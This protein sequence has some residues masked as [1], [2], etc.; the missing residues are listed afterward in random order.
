MTRANDEVQRLTRELQRDAANHAT[1]R[2]DYELDLCANAARLERLEAE[3]RDSLV[4]I[5]VLNAKGALFDEVQ[6]KLENLERSNLGEENQREVMTAALQVA[7]QEKERILDSMKE[8]EHTLD[9]LSMDKIYL[10]KEIQRQAEQIKKSETELERQQEKLREVKRSR[11]ELYNKFLVE[12]DSQ[13]AIKQRLQAEIARI[14]EGKNQE[15]EQIRK[16]AKATADEKVR[17]FREMRDEAMTATEMCR[18]ELRDSKAAYDELL[19]KFRELHR[20]SELKETESRGNLKVANFELDRLKVLL[21]ETK[22]ALVQI[23]LENETWAA[24]IQILKEKVK[25]EKNGPLEELKYELEKQVS[26]LKEE[27]RC[28]RAQLVVYQEEKND[29]VEAYKK[30]KDAK[31]EACQS[32]K[33]AQLDINQIGRISQPHV[34]DKEEEAMSSSPRYQCLEG[35]SSMK[36][37]SVSRKQINEEDLP[38]SLWIPIQEEKKAKH[39]SASR[40][41]DCKES[42]K[43]MSVSISLLKSCEAAKEKLFSASKIKATESHEAKSRGLFQQNQQLEEQL[44][45]VTEEKNRVTNR[46]QSVQDDIRKLLRARGSV[47]QLQSMLKEKGVFTG[48]GYQWKTITSSESSLKAVKKASPKISP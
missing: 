28:T 46:L 43:P 5:E 18:S 6:A 14:E 26:E 31:C 40:Y 15:V 24:K 13:L 44:R 25:E 8:K 32:R 12:K 33:D 23:K 20:V 34:P 47:E 41:E 22:D 10:S 3:H 4:Q 35:K 38:E 17:T 36:C 11:S 16:E 19:L 27:L 42:E 30:E 2:R 21:E 7:I 48:A 1:E 29:Q 45:A 37:S 39:S 9:L